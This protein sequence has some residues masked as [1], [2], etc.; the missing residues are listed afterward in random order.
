MD[1]FK[2]M[3]I[4]QLKSIVLKKGL[5][6]DVGKLKKNELIRILESSYE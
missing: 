3:T 4:Q 1:A 6:T 5:S 2:K